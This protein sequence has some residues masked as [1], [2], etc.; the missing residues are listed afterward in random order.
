M[1]ND[2]LMNGTKRFVV[3]MSHPERQ[4]T[5]AKVGVV[6]QLEDLKEVSEQT[7]DQVK[8]VCSH[9]VVGRVLIH[10]VLNPEVWDTRETYLR[11][12]GLVI[13][14]TDGED[15]K[16]KNMEKDDDDDDDD[17]DDEDDERSEEKKEIDESISKAA[18][19]TLMAALSKSRKPT[20]P[21]SDKELRLKEAF[22]ALVE[23]QHKNEEDIRFTTASI[24]TLAVAPGGGQT[25]LWMTVRLWQ[26]FIEQRLVGRQNE[27]QMEFQKKLIDFLK[28][29]KGLGENE[30]PSAI[31]FDDLSPSLQQEVKDL[32]KRMQQELKPLVLES[33]LTIQKILEC[34]DH[35]ERV[36]LLRYFVEAE[37]RRLDAKA[38][39]KGMFLGSPDAIAEDYVEKADEDE[40]KE[41]GGK[42]NEKGGA[43]EDLKEM[44]NLDADVGDTKGSLFTDDE[45][46]FQ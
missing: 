34:E 41:D 7:D 13:D 19:S 22:K 6:F 46:A 43:S 4:G 5:F 27:M 16:E 45:D 32:Q 3:A 21:L 14:E 37:K 18:Y 23:K 33:T 9:K 15:E 36:D 24:A 8:Y 44:M 17:D 31:G 35:G 10:R 20:P 40:G 11:V 42:E 39:L 28:K 30:L 26:S 29:E 2:I 1:Y 12:E 38:T 25:G